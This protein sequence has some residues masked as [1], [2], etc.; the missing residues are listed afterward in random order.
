MDFTKLCSERARH[1]T[2]NKLAI[3]LLEHVKCYLNQ[4]KY[5]HTVGTLIEAAHYS[6]ALFAQIPEDIVF[7]ACL[8]DVAKQWNR[9]ELIDY[10]KRDLIG[11][12]IPNEHQLHAYV[13]AIYAVN[14]FVINEDVFRAITYHTSCRAQASILE[15]II[16]LADWT[17]K[18]RKGRDIGHLRAV[19][20]A[21][22]F[23]GFKLSLDMGIKECIDK[24]RI[25][26]PDLYNARKYYFEMD[27][28]P[29]PE[30]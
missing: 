28:N 12:F 7:A 27:T 22:F 1:I 23:K 18:N 6:E 19:A 5:E 25:I 11:N 20:K 15:Q 9:E 17:D 8:H 2:K 24:G 4:E 21:D 3:D 26:Y 29:Y 10:W 30:K 16:Y 13:G 14:T